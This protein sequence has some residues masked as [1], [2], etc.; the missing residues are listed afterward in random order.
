MRLAW[1]ALL[2]SVTAAALAAAPARVGD[3]G[4]G[5][6]RQAISLAMKLFDKTS[7]EWKVPCISCHHQGLVMMAQEEARQHGLAV[8]EPVARAHAAK[9]LVQLAGLEGLLSAPLDA[10]SFGYGLAAA[11]ASGV[12]PNVATAILARRFI[13]NQLPDGHWA[14][15]DGRPP[16]S[17]GVYTSTAL[18]VRAIALYAPP[19]ME[20]AKAK[21][22]A[23]ARKWL[24]ENR[25]QSSEDGALRLLGL[26]W[27]NASAAEREAA[28]RDLLAKQLADGSW[29]QE[30]G[31]SGDAYATGESLYALR[32]SGVLAADAPN[33]QHGVRY[34]L[35]TQHSDGSWLVR[36]R[37]HS[38]AQISPPYMET[39][40][41]HGKD[42]VISLAGTAW[43]AMALS[44]ALPAVDSPAR[45]LPAPE[46]K[47][48]G[49][50]S[51]MEAAVLGTSTELRE[52]LDHGLDPNTATKGG[53]SLLMMAMPERDKVNLLLARGAKPTQPSLSA[54]L[55]YRQ[56]APLVKALLDRGVSAAP[57]DET[58]MAAPLFEAVMT[59][60]VEAAS[61][62]IQRGADPKPN[63]SAKE[64][65]GMTLLEASVLADDVPMVKLL[66]AQ[67]PAST[68]GIN[69]V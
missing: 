56:S 69:K 39:G 2:F 41:P 12:G 43:S 11:H 60:D 65:P 45:P 32:V 57:K 27:A 19:N 33:F 37:L 61:L 58:G 59:G 13:V 47:P 18:A 3:G 16:H 54:A 62:L 44:E 20:A 4:E 24:S 64:A 68:N 23:R 5:K 26:A 1:W 34:L 36:T 31:M 42:Q 55:S 17:A 28:G 63:P 52:L 22:L 21:V 53:A 66:L 8:D 25:G 67:E 51:W 40:F 46:L 48:K 49:V 7:A 14:A 30:D 10:N 15:G 50:E 35:Q 29:G 9:A 38:L 6:T